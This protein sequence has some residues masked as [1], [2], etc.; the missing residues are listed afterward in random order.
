[1]HPTEVKIAAS[2]AAEGGANGLVV[3]WVGRLGSDMAWAV[4]GE[5]PQA[6][7]V[8]LGGCSY[9]ADILG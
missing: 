5:Q 6:S 7:P 4:D 1:M 8:F 3:E 2:M 9:G